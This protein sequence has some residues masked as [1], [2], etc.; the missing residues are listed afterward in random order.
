[1]YRSIFFCIVWFVAALT[2]V[3]E[4]VSARELSTSPLSTTT[5]IKLVPFIS[6]LVHSSSCVTKN[7][8]ITL[9]GEN[10]GSSSSG[11]RIAFRNGAVHVHINVTSWSATKITVRFPDS[12][13]LSGG[14]KYYVGIE[15]TSE[16]ML[17]NTNRYVT[18]CRALT[19]TTVSQPLVDNNTI[20]T[21]TT[22]VQTQDD[23]SLDQYPPDVSGQT[24][25]PMSSG[26]LLGSQLPPPPEDLP[27]PPVKR[28][29]SIDPGELL[30][31]SA[32][33]VQAQALAKKA[34]S[35]GLR[36]KR[37]RYL[38]SL[39]MVISVFRVPKAV[40]V[41][42]ALKRLRRAAPK[43]W[44]D[45]NAR[46]QLQGNKSKRYGARLIGWNTRSSNKRCGTGMR[47][48]M[49]DTGIDKSHPA[50]KGKS[51][52]SRSFLTA[53]IRMAKFDH[54]TAAA[55]ILVGNSKRLGLRGLVRGAKLYVANVFRQRGSNNVDTTAEWVVQA[56]DW[57]AGQRVQIVNL[58]LGGPRNLLVEAAIKRLLSRGIVV[59]AAAGNGGSTAKPVYP[60]A[61]KGVLAVTA[62]DATF[63]PYYKANRGNYISLAA[64]G[65]DIW[66]ARAGGKG[67]VYVSG[68]SYATPF[69][70]A[71]L[72][73]ARMK[74]LKA[75][76]QKIRNR[77][78][79]RARDLGRSGKDPIFGWGLVRVKGKCTK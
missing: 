79:N 59:V 56:L 21:N 36:I 38:K 45:T 77:L 68:T 26:S 18:V 37:R 53:G 30:V 47:V 72:I 29:K 66:V 2:I 12:T 17:S 19:A 8:L 31:A 51:I 32:N 33:M 11:K 44:A 7:K 76:W 24:Q 9:S 25:M 27:P 55:S 28:D 78:I 42:P 6:T 67:G 60:A 3:A 74:A 41:G 14:Q 65:V 57:L 10:F 49:V 16:K 13:S 40:G 15:T 73:A 35:M 34:R 1:M 48:G 20:S 61:Q 4:P 39:G 5:T 71:S 46:Y 22:P 69:V 50:L 75:P 64:P 63:T 58:G 43:T 52:V 54:G 62:V 70:T 23:A